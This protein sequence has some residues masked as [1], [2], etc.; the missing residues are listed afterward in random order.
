MSKASFNLDQFRN[1]V[2]GGFGLARTNRFEVEIKPPPGLAGQYGSIS[3]VTSLYVEQA[4]VPLLNIFSKNFKIF[5]PT[6]RR[7]ITSEYGGEGLPIIFHVDRNMNV[8]TFIEDWMHLIINPTTFTVAYQESYITDINIRQIDEENN[9]TYEI[10]LLEAYP[11]N[12]NI[13]D[14]N[15]ASSNQTHRLTV[16]FAYRYWKRVEKTQPVDIPRPI[17]NPQVPTVDN[18]VQP[19]P[20]PST[21]TIP[22]FRRQFNP[23][24]GNLEEGTQG[25]D[26]P[27]SA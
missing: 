5:G 4:S 24:T 15:N 7:P 6:Y 26:L 21:P 11:T 18:R 9:V 10:Q 20:P 25:S 17:I 12:M 16:L 2:L 1:E 14:L 22:V 27:I 13:M 23:S 3:Q 19:L 8:R